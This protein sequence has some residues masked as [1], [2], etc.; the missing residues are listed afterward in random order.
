MD[1]PKGHDQFH[2]SDHRNSCQ[3]PELKSSNLWPDRGLGTPEDYGRKYLYSRTKRL[4]ASRLAEQLRFGSPFQGSTAAVHEFPIQTDEGLPE[5]TVEGIA[6][7]TQLNFVFKSPLRVK[8]SIL[9]QMRRACTR[10]TRA[11]KR[12][13]LRLR[14]DLRQC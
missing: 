5:Y 10:R 8:L 2:A 1:G 11:V 3:H 9:E 14:D 13:A 4:C 6:I 12:L 7:C